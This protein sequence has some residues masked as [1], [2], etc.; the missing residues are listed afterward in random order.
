[1]PPIQTEATANDDQPWITICLGSSCFTRGNDEHLPLLQEA[2]A[3]RGLESRVRLRGSRC[4]GQ[5]QHGP[6]LR[7]GDI[8]VPGV[9]A[10]DLPALLDSLS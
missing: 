8:L 10:A 7:V 9:R 5:C 4:E 1:M 3:A 2:I 6:N